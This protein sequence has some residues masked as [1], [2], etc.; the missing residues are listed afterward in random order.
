MDPFQ[1]RERRGRRPLD[2]DKEAR[3]FQVGSDRPQPIRPLHMEGRGYVVEEPGIVDE[4]GRGRAGADFK[5]SS[6]PF[7][8]PRDEL[9]TIENH[10][11]KHVRIVPAPLSKL[12]FI[13]SIRRAERGGMRVFSPKG[14]GVILLVGALVVVGSLQLGRPTSHVQADTMSFWEAAGR[15]LMTA[16]GGGGGGGRDGGAGP[17]PAGGSPAEGGAGPHRR[18]GAGGGRGGVGGGGGI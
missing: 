14:T 5:A 18:R 9:I 3:S 17:P 8:A 7:W 11:A 2:V 12:D 1:V 6:P 10:A 15:G 16:A 4:H 13:C